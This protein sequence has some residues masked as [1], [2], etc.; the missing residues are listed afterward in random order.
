MK[1]FNSQQ[2][3]SSEHPEFSEFWSIYSDSFPL[4]ERRDYNQQVA[5]LDR[6]GYQLDIYFLADKLVGFISYWKSGEFIF[7]EHLAIASDCQGKGLGS[8]LLK[9]FIGNQNFPVILEIEPPCDEKTFRRLRFYE[10]LGFIQNS[11]IHFQPPYHIGDQP[12]RLNIL[13]YPDQITKE[14]YDRFSSLQK[15]WMGNFKT[16]TYL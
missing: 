4:N 2:I 12:L 11:H 16:E 15:K 7:I 5:V 1:N 8:A 13:S 9:P 6:P 10:S 3:K 14:C